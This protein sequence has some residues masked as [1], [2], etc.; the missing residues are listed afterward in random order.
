MGWLRSVVLVL[1]IAPAYAA[2]VPTADVSWRPYGPDAFAEARAGKR[3]ILLNMEAV[4]CH[5]CHVMDATTYAD[6]EL[7]AYLE[8]HFVP[9]RADQDAR[10]D[11]ANRY[12]DYG[13]PATIVL[14]PD[15][16]EIV[17]RAGY[18]APD[19]MARLLRAIVADP[20]P[21]PAALPRTLPADAMSGELTDELRA[22]LQRRHV[23]MFDPERGGLR[24]PQKFIDRDALE[25]DLVLAG[26]G[27]AAA[28]RRARRTL[29]AARALVDPVWGGVYQYSTGGDWQHPHYEKLATIQAEYLRI[30]ALAW[31]RWQRPGDAAVARAIV[32]YVAAF[33]TAP[34]GAFHV[35]QDADVVPGEHAADYFGLDDAGRRAIGMPRIDTHVYAHENGRLIEALALWATVSGDADAHAMARRAHARLLAMRDA[36]GGV[37]RG[38]RL[39]LADNLSLGRACLALYAAMAERADLDCASRAARLIA[40]TFAH[41]Q[42]GYVGGRSEDPLPAVRQIDENIAVTRLLNLVAHYSGDAALHAAARHGLRYL[43]AAPVA[44]ERSTEAGV[45]IAARELG[46]DPLHLTVVGPRDAPAARRLFDR[47]AGWPATYKRVEWWDRREGPLM[48]PDVSYPDLPRPAAFVCTNGLCS[49]PLYDAA[50]LAEFVARR[51]PRAATL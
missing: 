4:W 36:D 19:N 21:E 10:P 15:G 18:I 23:A 25:Y 13:W 16:T 28:A 24:T 14:A 8:Q 3:L 5:W 48:N 39:Y 26:D 17:K 30:H 44:L 46:N 38:G 12:R 40:T 2:A 47:L 7:V 41:S 27:D 29:D 20:S 22:E 49:V 11:L 32:D 31:A 33:L 6:A 1:A 42:A 50:M 9:V 43:A 51:L 45:L 34:D 37:R 35:S